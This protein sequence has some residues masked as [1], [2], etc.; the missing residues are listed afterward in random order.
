MH[1]ADTC[2]TPSLSGFIP[3]KRCIWSGA[4]SDGMINSSTI[5]IAD[6]HV[7]CRWKRTRRILS[8]GVPPNCCTRATR[9]V[10]AS[11]A[12]A[13]IRHRCGERN[14]TCR[15]ARPGWWHDGSGGGARGCIPGPES[16]P[17]EGVICCGHFAVSGVAVG[18]HLGGADPWRIPEGDPAVV[19]VLF[20]FFL[21]STG[22][23]DD[24][25]RFLNS[26]AETINSIQF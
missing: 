13:Q 15:I 3:T 5:R 16:G 2:W 22:M 18:D 8:A 9:E 11:D 19:A 14:V 7:V 1:L 25:Q 20:G 17:T 10:T 24:I 23:A 26:I 21:A 12:P 6:E 4:D